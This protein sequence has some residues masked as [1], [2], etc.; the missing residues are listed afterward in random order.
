LR[1]AIEW[2]SD[3]GSGYIAKDPKRFARDLGFEPLTTPV[4]SPQSN[5][6]AEA[7]VRTIKRDYARV[8]PAPD[9]QTVIESLPAGSST[10][11]GFIRTAP[12]AIVRHESSSLRNQSGVP[13]PVF[14]GHQ[15]FGL[16]RIVLASYGTD[17]A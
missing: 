11:T 12:C 15:Q 8:N 3:N 9:A 10:T 16:H 7:L 5:G 13:C 1:R 14:R 6:M 2:L 4:A 17:R